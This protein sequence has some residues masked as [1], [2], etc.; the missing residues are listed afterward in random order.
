MYTGGLPDNINDED[1]GTRVD[2]YS[3]SG[4]TLSFVGIVW[5][6]LYTNVASL[7]LNLATFFDGGWFGVNG[8]TP[9]SGNTLSLTNLVEPAVQVTADGGST[10]MTVGH[11]SDYLTAMDGHPLPSVDFGPPTLGTS[12]FQLVGAVPGI[13]GIRII[14]SEGG[15][16]SAGFLGV[17]DV[18]VMTGPRLV[19]VENTRIEG[20]QF[21]FEFDTQAGF[22]HVVQYKNSVDD[23]EW[24]TLTTIPGDGTR[25]PVT[26]DL[27]QRV[28]IYRVTTEQ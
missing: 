27:T 21:R 19:H 13:D 11:V 22:D 8:I 1:L 26:D 2:S 14:G 18:K 25:Q 3:T 7:E 9:G 6:H 10:W 5:N 12:T 24:Q 16:A 15:I 17:F 20:G 28:R 4:D 23:T